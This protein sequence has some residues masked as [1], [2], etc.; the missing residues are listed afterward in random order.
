M[1]DEE[2][3][4]IEDIINTKILSNIPVSTAVEAFENAKA[5]GAIALFGEKYGQKVRVVEIEDTSCELCG[6][7]HVGATGEIGAFRVISES[8]IAAGVRRIEAITG[9]EVIRAARAADRELS[10]VSALLRVPVRD[11]E[12]GARKVMEKMKALE[13][14]VSELREQL[15]GGEVEAIVKRAVEVEGIMVAASRVDV[16]DVDVLKR[17]ADRVKEKIPGGIICVGSASDDRAYIVVAVDASVVETKRI[18][19]SAIAKKMG[20]LVGGRG[21]GK[22]TFAQAGGKEP[23]RLDE[24][25]KRCAEV[26]AGLVK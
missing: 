8:G 18:T 4:T 26:V 24:A 13:K 21:G 9:S 5:R 3:R 11:L 15:A 2:I 22:A 14:E 12:G 20:E 19:A 7:T 10:Q 25:I 23:G 1:T 16:A 17:L 6:G